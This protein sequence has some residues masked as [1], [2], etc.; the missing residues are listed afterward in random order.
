MQNNRKLGRNPLAYLGV[1]ATTPPQFVIEERDPTDNDFQEYVLGTLWFTTTITKLWL[2]ADKSPGAVSKWVEVYPGDGSGTN[3]F[4]TNSGTALEN[5]GTIKLLGSAGGVLTSVIAPFL[6]EVRLN[7]DDDLVITNSIKVSAFTQGTLRSSSIGQFSSLPDGTDG[8]VLIASSSGA[9]VWANLTQ[10]ANVTITNGSNSITIASSGGGGGGGL[11]ELVADSGSAII[12]GSNQITLAG[13]T[14]IETDGA[15]NTVTVTLKDN[16]VL[17]TAGSLSI[18]TPK[19][20][21]PVESLFW[22]KNQTPGAN[23]EEDC[24]AIGHN[25][26][27]ANDSSSENISLGTNTLSDLVN[28]DGL[29]LAIGVNNGTS[30][31]SFERNIFLGHYS[32]TISTGNN[33][34]IIGTELEG[35]SPSVNNEIKIGKVGVQDKCLVAGIYGATGLDTTNGAV[36]IDTDGRMVSSVGTA[37]QVLTSTA[38][39]VEWAA[40]GGGGS[41][42][43][44]AFLV[45]MSHYFAGS[46]TETLGDTFALTTKF[47]NPTSFYPGNGAG[48]Y[49]RFTAPV[50]GIYLF[51]TAYYN[52]LTY[53]VFNIIKGDANIWQSSNDIESDGSTYHNTTFYASMALGETLTFT[54]STSQSGTQTIRFSGYLLG[55]G[56]AAPVPT[57][58]E[59]YAFRFTG[60]KTLAEGE[61]YLIGSSAIVAPNFYDASALY[62]GNG[63]GAP[64]TFTAQSTGTYLFYLKKDPYTGYSLDLGL[65]KNGVYTA[66]YE[67]LPVST[68]ISSEYRITTSFVPLV[69]GDIITFRV[70]AMKAMGPETPTWTIWGYLL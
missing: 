19:L 29:N 13:S 67:Y 16:V 61:T 65:M 1:E 42:N 43:S 70:R 23:I 55:V 9:P 62:L 46:G 24:I 30:G 37:G 36:L 2:L 31:T 5:A 41:A 20:Q 18:G 6:D 12:N 27:T 11:T 21:A 17:T 44:Y 26:Q 25:S 64:A 4:E 35:S 28:G 60:T 33:N 45:D 58:S 22:G 14:N 10:G 32:G 50:A 54:F 48:N 66:G 47:Y 39:G 69:A 15:L 38:T 63:V 34:I 59:S 57:P 51:N 3:F 68:G 52:G 40:G 56:G 8:Q 53:T 7:L 49:A